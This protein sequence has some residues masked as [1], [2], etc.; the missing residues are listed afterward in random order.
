MRTTIASLSILG[1][2]IAAT[3]ISAQGLQAIRSEATMRESQPLVFTAG[4]SGGYD[5]LNYKADNLN[6]EDIDSFFIQSG[7][8]L[9]YGDAD[10]TTPWSVGSDFGVIRYLDDAPDGEDT[11][12]S[13][14]VSFDIMHNASRRLKFVNNFYLTYE[15][16]PNYS[17]GASTALRNGQ[18][19]Y[20]YNNFAVS[21]AW[22]ERFTTTTSYT[23]DGI[24][25]D[26]SD[27]S[28]FEDRLSHVI[29]QQF[30]Y[31]LNKRTQLVAEYRYRMTNYDSADNDYTSN[32]FLVG[33][34]HR[35]SERTSGSIRAGVEFYESDRSSETAPYA[36]AAIDHAVSK[37]TTGR[38][39]ASLGF[40]GAELGDYE[41]RY[42]TRIGGTVN[43]RMT[44]RFSVN[45]GTHAAFSQYKGD[46]KNTQDFDETQVH[47]S[48]GLAYRLWNNVSM[49]AQYS[50]T[51]LSSGE[52][53]RE[54]DRNR[55][56]IGLSA[57]F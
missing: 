57:T 50:Y 49:D 56:S 5:N 44:E 27:V 42:A 36:E 39:Y 32:Y 40:D 8:G 10:Q 1:A 4:V 15:V 31:S 2:L 38:L 13:A 45:A 54:Y 46:G 35:W 20:G 37:K 23:V 52:E 14:R 9:L 24:R 28:G 34:D 47:A 6:A 12:Y 29:A 18:Y 22:S 25:Y 48:A 11:Y 43:H 55:I 33:A 19:L 17:I 41:S 53:A 26:D 3:H 7:V 16:E 51:V 30:A 21:Y